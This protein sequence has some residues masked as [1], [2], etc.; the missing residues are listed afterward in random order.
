ARG[1]RRDGRLGDRCLD[2]GV[3]R[4]L[5]HERFARRMSS[6]MSSTS[7]TGTATSVDAAAIVGSNSWVT[8]VYICTGRVWKVGD[9]RNSA[10]TTSSNEVT[11]ANTAPVNTPRLMSG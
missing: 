6:G 4:F 7:V 9:R 8:A 5:L 1:S 11:K 10:I 2:R 3:H